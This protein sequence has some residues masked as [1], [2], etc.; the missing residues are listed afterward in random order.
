M[1]VKLTHT[2][3]RSDNILIS[4]EIAL[5][6]IT[7]IT[8]IE[9]FRCGFCCQELHNIMIGHYKVISLWLVEIHMT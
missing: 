8:F 1:L 3:T 5:K 4:N 6:S 7:K 2:H 9:P